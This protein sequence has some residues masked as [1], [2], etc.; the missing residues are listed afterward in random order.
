MAGDT[1]DIDKLEEQ[2]Q[3]EKVLRGEGSVS[4]QIVDAAIVGTEVRES[5]REKATFETQFSVYLLVEISNGQQY[6][7]AIKDIFDPEERDDLVTLYRSLDVPPDATLD[8][9][10]GKTTDLSLPTQE[11]ERIELSLSGS[12]INAQRTDNIKQ[13]REGDT[14]LPLTVQAAHTRA[15]NYVE[16]ADEE[17]GVRVPVAGMTTDDD[18]VTIDL[19]DGWGSLS[20]D[21]ETTQ[22]VDP[23]TPYE[24]LIE[25]VGYGSVSQIEEGDLYVAHISEFSLPSKVVP[26]DEMMAEA[27]VRHAQSNI[28]VMTEFSMLTSRRDHFDTMYDE[29]IMLD[30]DRAGVWAIFGSADSL[31]RDF[32]K[33]AVAAIVFIL[34]FLAAALL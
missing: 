20:V 23:E 27:R 7:V 1:S 12:Q 5:V 2:Y 11:R 8:A 13:I 25:Y 24:R 32:K 9:L 17:T 30:E 34:L 26:K 14:E 22:E 16:T 10:L 28:G 18:E 4:G 21:V 6:G 29:F 15:Y 19:A 33:Y 31:N 3:S